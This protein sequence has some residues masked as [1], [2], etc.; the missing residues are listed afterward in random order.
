MIPPQ[1]GEP[2]GVYYQEIDRAKLVI[3]LW[4]DREQGDLALYQ[5]QGPVSIINKRYVDSIEETVVGVNGLYG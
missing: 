4:Q 1:L 3:M 5:I 2:D